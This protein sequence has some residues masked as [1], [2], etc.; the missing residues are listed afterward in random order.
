MNRVSRA[1]APLLLGI[2]VTEASS[3]PNEMPTFPPSQQPKLQKLK[4]GILEQ[5]EGTPALWLKV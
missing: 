5:D 1:S 3:T 2:A 4:K